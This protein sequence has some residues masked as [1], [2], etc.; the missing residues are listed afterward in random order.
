MLRGE[1]S[2]N[3]KKIYDIERLAGKVAYGTINARD[4]IALKNSLNQVP[5]VK[6]LLVNT[7]STILNYLYHAFQ[8]KSLGCLLQKYQMLM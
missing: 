2:E 3:L 8:N 7:K 4:L 1:L 6:S 5:M